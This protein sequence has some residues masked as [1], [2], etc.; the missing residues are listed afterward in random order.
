MQLSEYSCLLSVVKIGRDG[1]ICKPLSQLVYSV[2]CCWWQSFLSYEIT[3]WPS[4]HADCVLSWWIDPWTRSEAP[5]VIFLLLYYNAGSEASIW[6]LGNSSHVP[7]NSF[8]L[9]TTDSSHSLSLF[10]LPLL[11]FCTNS[12]LHCCRPALLKWL[13]HYYF[14]LS[15]STCNNTT[16]VELL[17]LIARGNFVMSASIT[18]IRSHP[19]LIHLSWTCLK[20]LIHIHTCTQSP[21]YLHYYWTC[22]YPPTIPHH[23]ITPLPPLHY[24]SNKCPSLF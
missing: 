9:I 15:P 4:I 19:Q 17:C 23:M 12:H 2:K 7:I 14:T 3:Q 1:M 10:Y 24:P 22:P 5:Q 6:N 13:L 20:C 8:S 18:T 16:E 11:D 21:L